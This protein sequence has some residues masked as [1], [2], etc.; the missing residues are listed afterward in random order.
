MAEHELPKD[1]VAFR[2]HLMTVRRF[3]KRDATWDEYRWYK[4]GCWKWYDD[5][6]EETARRHFSESEHV[7]VATDNT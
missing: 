3:V 4:T 7:F 6:G 5:V 1:F 2:Q